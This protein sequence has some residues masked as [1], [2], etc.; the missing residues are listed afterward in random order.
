MSV[1]FSNNAKTTLSSGITSSATSITVA[2]GSVFPSISGSEYF[3]LTLEVDS[4]AD[5]REIAKCTARSG[6]T[7]TITRGQDGTSAR[8]FSSGDKCELRLNAA[9]LN[10][11]V[12]GNNTTE[13]LLNQ[14]TGDGSTTS[15]TLSNSPDEN[16]TNV[17]LSGVY[18]SKSNYSISGSSLT[19]STAPPNGLA[20]EIMV[21]KSV[22]ISI[23]TPADDSVTTAK[24]ADDSVTSDKLSNAL[25]TKIAGIEA[26]ADV[27]DTANVT[28]AGALM[29]SELTSEA[30][31]KALNQGVATGDSPTFAGLT[32]GDGSGSEQILVDAGAGW[33]DLKLHSD[34]TNGGSIYFNDGADAGQIFYYHPEN[35]MRFHTAATE[36]ARLDSSGNLLVGQTTNAETGTG[37][38][39]VPDGTSHMYSGGTDALMLGRGGSDGDILSFNKS[40]T[41]VGSIGS[42][43][44]GKMSVIGANQNL[45]IGANGT[46]VF[47]VST[48]SVYPQTDN[49][50]DLGFSSSSNRFKD[51]HLSGTANVGVSRITGQNLAHSASTLAIGHEGSSKSQLRA[52]G[53]NS[54][55]AGSLEFM[56]SNSSGGGS[57]SMTLTSSGELLVGKTTNDINTAGHEFLNYGRALHTVNASTVQILNRKSNDGD[58]ALF[59]KD[60]S[61]VGSIGT[62]GG[63]LY[64]DGASGDIG[65]YMGSNNLYPR[66]NGAFA[67][68]AVDIGQSSYRFKDLHLSGR[69]TSNQP[70]TCFTSSSSITLYN[71]SVWRKIALNS[72]KHQ[73]GGNHFNSGSAR[74]TAP[75][76]GRYLFGMDI[77]LESVSGT[78]TWMYIVPLVNGSTNA[79]NGQAFADFSPPH[80]TYNRRTGT[81]L[82]NLSAN[83]YVEMWQIGAGNGTAILKA[84]TES[85]FFLTL[86]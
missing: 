60:G 14:F 73:T 9:A 43:S 29:D 41:T 10:D 8:T 28:A 67:D 50:V 25:S 58:I 6:N 69:I 86:L 46:N 38:G 84:N 3:Y 42:A 48:T 40:G 7:L 63:Q 23:A 12:V 1:K 81:F 11:A 36:R 39:L 49:A 45:Q 70:S 27:T 5:L 32:V 82:L 66:K 80:T 17:F 30:S 83:D 4:D 56:V 52:Y 51:L 22:E 75:V 34:A 61:S 68:N 76:A 57:H 24:I 65:L 19:F 37:I 85:S 62:A 71:D 15:F 33:A 35:S 18:Q 26:S 64:I 55:T 53:A 72:T 20:I 2:D 54:S 79:N 59:Q 74:F 16:L 44:G 77:Q 31:V 13:M 47:N 78:I 21:A